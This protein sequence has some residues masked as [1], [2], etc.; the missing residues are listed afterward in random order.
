MPSKLT[1]ITEVYPDLSQTTSINKH[2]SFLYT[3]H[4]SYTIFGSLD[5]ESNVKGKG[6]FVVDTIFK[7][8]GWS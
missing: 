6:F 5:L 2:F 3:P 8:N 4:S 7:E 1:A